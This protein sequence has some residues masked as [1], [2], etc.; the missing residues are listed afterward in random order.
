MGD[1]AIGGVGM[2]GWGYRAASLPQWAND[3]AKYSLS[4]TMAQAR[5][6]FDLAIR[7]P[8]L[9]GALDVQLQ[10]RLQFRLQSEGSL[11]ILFGFGVP[12]QPQQNQSAVPVSKGV[13]RVEF[14]CAIEFPDRALQFVLVRQ[15][16][17]AAVVARSVTRIERDGLVEIFQRA[18]HA[19]LLA[20]GIAAIE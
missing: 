5:R 1:Y 10:F 2:R 17:R 19:P 16:H 4:A 15:R 9:P 11:E 3:E 12:A 20:S 18:V 7:L 13:A 14:D 8:P 6:M